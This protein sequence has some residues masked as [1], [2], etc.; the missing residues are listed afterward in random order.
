MN[1]KIKILALTAHID[2]SQINECIK[3]IKN[4]KNVQVKQTIISGLPAIEAEK[5]IYELFN[6]NRNNYDYFVKID[7]DMVLESPDV[8]ETI[9]NKLTILRSRNIERLTIPVLDFYSGGFIT[10]MH[11]LSAKSI[12]TKINS[13]P[14]NNPDKWIGHIPGKIIKKTKRIYV[15]HGYNPT[16]SQSFRYGL[17]RGIK[18]KSSQYKS[19]HGLDLRNLYHNYQK[20]TGNERL[21]YAVI[22]SLLGM[23]YIEIGNNLTSTPDTNS[24]EFNKLLEIT[25]Q[26][27]INEI[28]ELIKNVEKLIKQSA[29]SK[30]LQYL[31]SIVR[32]YIDAKLTNL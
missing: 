1:E 28:V 15:R 17:H 20:N 32:N 30:P 3:S 4:Q 16:S 8:L 13:Y 5:R 21:K 18:F 10:G 2:E 24:L 22:G 27:P 29:T 7:A 12:P 9:T 11:T 14:I 23:G 25:N 6:E 31:R 19:S 26:I